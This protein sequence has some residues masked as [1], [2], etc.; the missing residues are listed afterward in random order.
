LVYIDMIQRRSAVIALTH[1]KVERVRFLGA[2]AFALATFVALSVRIGL[3]DGGWLLFVPALG[4]ACVIV[5]PVWP[6]LL[7]AILATAAILILGSMSVGILYGFAL[8]PLIFALA[9]FRRD[10]GRNAT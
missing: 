7:V 9:E 10:A 1:K 2:L 3:N 6:I 4:A 8:A 5:W